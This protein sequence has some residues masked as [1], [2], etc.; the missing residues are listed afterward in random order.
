MFGLCQLTPPLE[1]AVGSVPL[2][3][4]RECGPGESFWRIFPSGIY[5]VSMVEPRS[6][7]WDGVLW[8]SPTDTM[9]QGNAILEIGIKRETSRNF[10]GDLFSGLMHA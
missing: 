10:W 2:P 9:K 6:A 1:D 5:A 3:C 7:Q 4:E 8:L